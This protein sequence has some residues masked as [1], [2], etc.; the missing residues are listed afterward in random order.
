MRQVRPLPR[1]ARSYAHFER[2]LR[3]VNPSVVTAVKP[4]PLIGLIQ[5]LDGAPSSPKGLEMPGCM[6]AAALEDRLWLPRLPWH[7]DTAL[8][9]LAAA[10]DLN[11][12]SRPR[13]SDAGM[14]KQLLAQVVGNLW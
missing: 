1:V 7:G 6:Q 10:S 8:G 9:I 12:D 14:A 13:A 3:Y 4:W 5:S 11:A 2:W